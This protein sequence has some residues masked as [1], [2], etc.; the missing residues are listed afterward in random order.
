M[1]EHSMP[2]NL[3]NKKNDLEKLRI[4]DL[5]SAATLDA[6]ETAKEKTTTTTEF[7][8]ELRESGITNMWGAGKYIEMEFGVSKNQSKEIL[9]SWMKNFKK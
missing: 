9:I 1:I 3:A 2:S 5:K 6:E 7:L 4:K 8:N